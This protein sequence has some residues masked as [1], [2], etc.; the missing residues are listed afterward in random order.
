[1]FRFQLVSLGGVKFDGEVAEVTLPT[2][3]GEIGVL[4][5]HM[6]LISVASTG[7]IT[8]RYKAN[9]PDDFREYFAVTG[10]VIEVENNTLRIL[11]DEA[12]H[13]DEI[14]EA[15]V[16]AAMELAEK[17]KAE[18]TDQHSL[19]KAQQLIDRQAVRL[20][21]AGLKRRNRRG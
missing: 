7:R 18:A 1:M 6:P 19:E 2:L 15:E 3:D 20:Q 8:I 17:M 5:S 12:D 21:V 9:D 14:S 10:G 4:T 16:K 11:V 13:A